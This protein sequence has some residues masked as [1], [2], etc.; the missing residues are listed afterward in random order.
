MIAGVIVFIVLCVVACGCGADNA[1]KRRGGALR[2]YGAAMDVR[3]T[4]RGA[5][6]YG[7]RVARRAVFRAA[8]RW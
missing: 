1:R 7:R 6:A 3:A 5:G 4:G 8:R 2:A